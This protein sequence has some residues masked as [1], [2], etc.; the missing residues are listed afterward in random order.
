MKN[1]WNAESK[2]MVMLRFVSIALLA[3]YL[4]I[5]SVM[6]LP[7]GTRM[8]MDSPGI[9]L[10]ELKQGENYAWLRKVR[11][12]GFVVVSA[13]DSGGAAE[14]AHITVGDTIW[15]VDG[16]SL[17][18][19]PQL[20]RRILG[21]SPGQSM[22]LDL[23]RKGKLLHSTI[24]LTSEENGYA[25]LSILIANMN[26]IPVISAW[27]F[28]IVGTLIGVLKIREPVAYVCS[29]FFLCWGIGMGE[30]E[31]AAWLPYSAM[32]LILTFKTTASTLVFPLGLRLFS[33]FPNPSRFGAFLLRWLWLVFALFGVLGLESYAK[34]LGDLL[35]GFVFSPLLGKMHV[36]IKVIW[37]SLI[38]AVCLCSIPLYFSQRKATREH[39]EQ[40]FKIIET[41]LLCFALSLF[42]ALL[43]VVLGAIV[44]SAWPNA[45]AFISDFF[46]ALGVTAIAVWILCNLAAPLSFAYTIL[47]RKIFGI[48]FIIRKGLQHLFLSKGALVIEGAIVFLIV[49]QIITHGGMVLA[50]SPTMVSAISVGVGIL[51]MAGL[52]RVNRKVMPALDRRFFREALDVRR[53]LLDLNQQLS[54]LRESHEILRQTAGTL[55]ATL[56]PSRIVFLLRD[57]QVLNAVHAVEHPRNQSVPEMHTTPRTSLQLSDSRIHELEKKSWL[58]LQDGDDQDDALRELDCELGIAIT[59]SSGLR[60]MMAL[61]DKFSE[62]PY[63]KDDR[64]LLMTVA[65]TMGLS[66]ENTELLE[67]AKREAELSKELEIARKVQQTLFPK[68]LPVAADWEFAGVCHPAKAVGGD[69][70]DVFEADPGTVIIALGDVTGKGVGPSFVMSGVHSTIRTQAQ[71]LIAEP[72]GVIEELNQYLFASTP[73]DMF[74]TLF[75]GIIELASGKVRYVNCGHPPALLI[76]QRNGIRGKLSS[77]GLGLGMIGGMKFEQGEEFLKAGES[78][79]IYSD[80]ITEA[81]NLEKEMY[82]EE[83]LANTLESSGRG[84]AHEILQTILCSVNT[85]AQG[86]EQADDISIVVVHHF[87]ASR[88]K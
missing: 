34:N 5:S 77:T 58:S 25:V 65:H 28:L 50:T 84:G 56:H 22:T 7:G 87:T 82:E 15:A 70:Y 12:E 59:G 54:T 9:S 75:I 45:P 38:V 79:V 24:E 20:F 62:E 49:Q 74:V 57:R 30:E 64:E 27:M 68:K 41:V 80:G 16:V 18:T 52:S 33:V 53:I 23:T 73:N 10:Q 40:R 69:Y 85:F 26:Y 76:D 81:I 63:S 51:G 11:T 36:T 47:T 13:V 35:G 61:G 4:L 6:S 78:L 44:K 3:A 55:L 17:K 83:R 48:K 32:P 46:M 1:I 14:K 86:C 60:G 39:P 43:F 37:I 31:T 88:R 71:R 19:T 2:T 66:L 21:L 72:V 67:V 8:V 29:L 42:A